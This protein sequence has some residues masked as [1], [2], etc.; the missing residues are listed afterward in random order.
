MNEIQGKRFHI[1][2]IVQGVGFR[3][4]VYGLA[5]R[6]KLTGWVR[7]TS[8][9]VDIEADGS[10]EA[11]SIFAETVL[12]EAPPLARIDS[13]DIVDKSPNG[14]SCFEIIQSEAV[15]GA[16]QPISPDVSIC[17]DCLRELFDPNDRRFRYPFINCT[18]C[19]PRFTIIKDIPYDRP[20]TTMAPF[21]MCPA[22]AAE[23]KNPLDRRFHAQPVAC[24]NCGPQIW[25]EYRVPGCDERSFSTEDQFSMG[26]SA[27]PAASW[28]PG[29]SSR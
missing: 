2:G 13:I 3:P 21:S 6:L 11:L 18:N 12:H 17:G 29:R 26:T 16:Y 7:N 19:G 20:F 15:E 14:F 8:A 23:Y 27:T 9:G 10:P 5:L 4:F 1:T 28:P 24:P 25:L 22:C